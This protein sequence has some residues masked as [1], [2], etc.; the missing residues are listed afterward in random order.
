MKNK[1]N[2][3]YVIIILALIIGLAGQRFL[4]AQKETL[5]IYQ[6]TYYD[7]CNKDVVNVAAPLDFTMAIKANELVASEV[8]KDDLNYQKSQCITLTNKVVRTPLLT[9]TKYDINHSKGNEDKAYQLSYQSILQELKAK[10]D[11]TVL[12]EKVI[13]CLEYYLAKSEYVLL[14]PN[15]SNNL[16]LNSALIGPDTTALTG[17]YHLNVYLEV[18]ANKDT[19]KNKTYYTFN[20]LSMKYEKE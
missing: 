17:I 11:K 10:K 14:Y 7:D 3:I 19:K 16:Q 13:A 9:L 8:I 20:A 1:N 5:A 4:S 12:D 18:V 6:P 2:K 15:S